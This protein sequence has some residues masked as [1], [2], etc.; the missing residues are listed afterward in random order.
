MIS[1][2]KF[3]AR[4]VPIKTGDKAIRPGAYYE[5]VLVTVE[6]GYPI[7]LL[8]IDTWWPGKGG[9]DAIYRALERGET[10]EAQIA[11]R[12]EFEEEEQD[13][14]RRRNCLAAPA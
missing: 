9:D 6:N 4:L 10:L 8:H 14:F 5:Q 11:F 3:P 7:A 13:E 12:V 2:R 1:E